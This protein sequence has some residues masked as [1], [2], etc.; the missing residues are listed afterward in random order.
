MRIQSTLPPIRFKSKYAAVTAALRAD[1]LQALRATKIQHV[2]S[3]QAFNLGTVVLWTELDKYGDV[4]DQ[5]QRHGHP[6]TPVS[7][8]NPSTV[9]EFILHTN[10]KTI[11]LGVEVEDSAAP[12]ADYGMPMDKTVDPVTP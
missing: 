5:L 11:T 8:S 1:V 3:I 4:I 7:P 2:K 9:N 10:G 12:Y 6:F